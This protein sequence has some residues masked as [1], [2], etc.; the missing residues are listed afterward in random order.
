MCLITATDFGVRVPSYFK[1]QLVHECM[2]RTLHEDLGQRDGW[3]VT[4]TENIWKSPTFYL[5]DSPT[6]LPH[7]NNAGF[8]MSH[9]RKASGGTGHTRA[10][11]H[12]YTFSVNGETLIAMH[13][14]FFEGAAWTGWKSNQPS[15][16]SY[17]AL[18]R[19]ST[20]MAEQHVDEITPELIEE[21]LSAYSDASHYAVVLHW[22]NQV[23]ALRGK[24]RFLAALQIGNGYLVH[25]S[26]PVLRIM[27]DYVKH[28]YDIDTPEPNV[29]TDNTMIRFP[30]GSL[31]IQSYAL[32]PVHKRDTTYSRSGADIY[33]PKAVVVTVHPNEKRNVGNIVRSNT[34]YTTAPSV[35]NNRTVRTQQQ[36]DAETTPS[37]VATGASLKERRRMW[38]TLAGKFA[39]LRRELST[40]YAASALGYVDDLNRPQINSFIVKTSMKELEL[41]NHVF[42]PIN[43]NGSSTK[44]FSA[45]SMCMINWWNHI[46][47][48]GYDIDVHIELFGAKPFWLDT[49][50]TLIKNDAGNLH[51]ST[52]VMP[53]WTSYMLRLFSSL[54]K[55]QIYTWLDTR[56]LERIL[57][58]NS[59]ID[60]PRT[61]STAMILSA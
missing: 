31:D 44:P 25:T 55:H 46:V 30:L 4:D 20:M 8:I 50:Y 14:G 6:W 36:P 10:E 42:F 32:N 17:R 59:P 43:A 35:T 37:S 1:A 40:M 11:N 61:E 15:T 9:L 24:T 49:H 22:K 58:E 52:V 12:P 7:V 21:W 19:L 13:N 27:R 3:G 48:D 53:I 51:D 45:T 56:I 29:I 18:L 34:D 39:P 57:A 5:E 33:Y 60:E 28:L 41:I 16:D 26:Y 54:N 38:S 23:Y 2:L 47:R